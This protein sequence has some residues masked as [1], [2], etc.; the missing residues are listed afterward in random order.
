[1]KYISQKDFYNQTI[2][3]GFDVDGAYG[4]QCVDFFNYFNKIV[5]DTYINCRPSGYAKSIFENRA[6]NGALKYYDVVD[7]KDIKQ[8]D[9]VIWGNCKSAPKSHV[10]MFWEKKNSTYGIFVGKNQNGTRETN[11]CSVTYDGIIGVLRPKIYVSTT[12]NSTSKSFFGSKG[13]FSFGDNHENIGKIAEFMY[14]TFP[15][16]TDKRALGNYYGQ[17]IQA[18]IKEFQRRA[19]AEGNYNA[20]V[21]GCVGVITLAS[22]KKYGFVE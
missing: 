19:K 4:I 5:N 15:K 16:Y 3:K 14:K 6:N 21:D 12:T 11:L 9:W 20:E 17:Y 1:M 18:S 22:L 2:G 8:G 10:A 7:L 13:Y